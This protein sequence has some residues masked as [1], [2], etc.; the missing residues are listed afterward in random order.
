ML[1]SKIT[2]K[3]TKKQLNSKLLFIHFFADSVDFVGGEIF[4]EVH[5]FVDDA[6]W[7]EFDDAVAYC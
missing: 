2:C 7:C 3:V 1:N 4:V 6:V 5:I